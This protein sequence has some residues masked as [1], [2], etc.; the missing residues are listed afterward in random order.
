[1]LGVF[2]MDVNTCI[3]KYLKM[4][5]EI[6]QVE[7]MMSGSIVGK[8]L[9]VARGRQRFDPKPLEAEVKGLVRTYLGDGGTGEEIEDMPLRFQTSNVGE[10]HKCNVSVLHLSRFLFPVLMRPSYSF[11][12][13]TSEKLGRPFRFRSYESSWDVVDDCPIWQACRATSAAPTFFPP[14]EIGRP[15]TA[16]I[17]GGLGYNNPIRALFDES[18]H[19]WPDRKIGCIASIG[20]GVPVFRDIGRT[21]KPLFESLKDMATDTEKV[22]REVEEEMKYKYGIEQQTYFRFNVQHGL[23]HVGLEE[24]KELDRTKIATQDYLNAQWTR[25]EQCASQLLQP[26]CR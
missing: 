23:G 19:V 9:N 7:D 8:I 4:T 24:W 26:K 11:V 16:Y 15:P 5:P 18:S 14:M 1:M 22:T 13:V 2:R 6:F 25:V 20:T 10:T 17:D 12:C 3:D 21:I